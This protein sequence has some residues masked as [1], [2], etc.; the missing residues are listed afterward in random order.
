MTNEQTGPLGIAYEK[1][2]G[3]LA[4]GLS[5]GLLVPFF[6]AIFVPDSHLVQSCCARFVPNLQVKRDETM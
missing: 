6:C 5:S 1:W 4:F 2:L 3:I